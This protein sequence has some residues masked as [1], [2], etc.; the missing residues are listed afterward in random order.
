MHDTEDEI[1]F[2]K[3]KSD[4]L[5]LNILP[6]N[7]AKELKLYGKTE[8]QLHDNVTIMFTDFKDFTKISEELTAKD[9]VKIIDYY[10][11][12][13]DQILLKYKIEKIKTIGDAYMCVSGFQTDSKLAAINMILCAQEILEM[14]NNENI[15]PKNSTNRSFDIRI[16]INTGSIVAGVVGETKFAYDI[17]GDAV[18]VASRMEKLG[19]V[20]S[21]NVSEATYN[22][23]RDNFNFIS[24]GAIEVKNKGTMKMYNLKSKDR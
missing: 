11:R 1:K 13:F 20:N 22:I 14:V 5:L 17:W 16:G 10:F 7:V 24:R 12:A 23:V 3:Q 15:K 8:A 19:E 18:N 4:N 2:E 21:I 6:S 9:L